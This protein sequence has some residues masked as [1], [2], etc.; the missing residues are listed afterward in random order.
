MQNLVSADKVTY[1]LR[2]ERQFREL[3]YSRDQANECIAWI[4][5]SE[6]RKCLRYEDSGMEWDDYVTTHRGPDGVMRRIYIK[7]RIPSPATVDYV[8]VTSFHTEDLLPND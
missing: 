6:L 4:D 1:S 8:L 7:L 3:G 5:L 2:A